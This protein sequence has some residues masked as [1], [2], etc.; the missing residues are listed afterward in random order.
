VERFNRKL[1]GSIDFA[2]IEVVALIDLRISN[3]T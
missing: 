3:A 1:E 2:G